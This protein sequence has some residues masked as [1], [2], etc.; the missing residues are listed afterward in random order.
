VQ[1]RTAQTEVLNRE[2]E[3]FSY[4]VSHDLRAPLRWIGGFAKALDEDYGGG[5]DVAG[6]QFIQKIR[7]SADHMSSLLDAL[8]EV[9]RFS[10]PELRRESVDLSALARRVAAELQLRAPG[11]K[12]EFVAAEGITTSGDPRLLKRVLENLLGNAYK[13][14]ATRAIG[15]IEFGVAPQN[16]GSATYFVRDNGV[17][18]DMAYADKLFGVF[19]R[20][21][22]AKEFPG[23][24]IGLATVERIIHR[25]GGRVWAEGTENLGAIFYFTLQPVPL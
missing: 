19:Q 8:L 24:G 11:R 13:F 15:Q 25:H 10:R 22:S 5:P 2:W 7:T 14:T 17:G 1:D 3:A 12:V 4:S 20:L 16:D 6:Q 18:F 23:T 9:A 21:H